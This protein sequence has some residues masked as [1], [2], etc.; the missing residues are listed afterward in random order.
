[1][2]STLLAGLLTA[3][4]FVPGLTLGT[5]GAGDSLFASP[6]PPTLAVSPFV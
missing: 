5:G 4:G 2:I 3:V 1:M 6:S